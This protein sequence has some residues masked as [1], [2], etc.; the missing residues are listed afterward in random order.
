MRIYSI[1]KRKMFKNKRF[2]TKGVTSQ[3]SLLLWFFMRQCIDK[4]KEIEKVISVFGIGVDMDLM[5]TMII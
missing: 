2:I 1:Q 5:I 4:M 3:V